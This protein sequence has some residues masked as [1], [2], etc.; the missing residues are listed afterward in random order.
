[1]P[2]LFVSLIL[3]LPELNNSIICG[4]HLQNTT[5]VVPN[6]CSQTQWR[7]FSRRVFIEFNGFEVIKFGF[8]TLDFCDGL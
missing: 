6:G 1:M 8:M 5:F 4:E 2:S 7:L 3:E